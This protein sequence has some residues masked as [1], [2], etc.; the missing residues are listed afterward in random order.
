MT[1]RRI[2]VTLMT[3]VP[4][5]VLAPAAAWAG[6]A[7]RPRAIEILSYSIGA[8]NPIPAER[9]HMTFA[10]PMPPDHA[11]A[12][13]LEPTV[14]SLSF[15]DEDGNLLTDPAAPPTLTIPRGG[16]RTASI[17]TDCAYD[18]C[19]LL[20]DTGDGD[21]VE[22]KVRPLHDR[23]LVR[24]EVVCEAGF[25]GPGV[26][27]MTVVARHDG[28]TASISYHDLIWSTPM[29]PGDATPPPGNGSE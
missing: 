13:G 29:L 22:M 16:F 3:L 28:S 21:P 27:G 8:P 23:V 15:Y 6:D 11:V 10:T 4:S 25:C 1:H 20:V 19:T 9:V 17:S 24:R 26:S 18:L 12:G 5:I 14:L 7:G 2:L